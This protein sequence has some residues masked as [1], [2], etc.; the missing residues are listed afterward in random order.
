MDP[1]AADLF[2]DR[3]DSPLS[4]TEN[5]D[6]QHYCSTRRSTQKKPSAMGSPAKLA[7]KSGRAPPPQSIP[8]SKPDLPLPDL[9]IYHLPSLA[10]LASQ[11]LPKGKG[12]GL[13]AMKSFT[14]RG[15]S[16]AA[17]L[18]FRASGEEPPPPLSLRKESSSRDAPGRQVSGLALKIIKKLQQ[19]GRSGKTEARPHASHEGSN[20][21]GRAELFAR[22]P[23]DL[24][25]EAVWLLERPDIAGEA[26]EQLKN[27]MNELESL[28][29]EK[30]SGG[31]RKKDRVLHAH[32]SKTHSLLNS[33]VNT[34]INK[35][36]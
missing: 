10:R 12:K 25:K 29:N 26:K 3:F 24:K 35:T 28:K 9:G 6:Y 7:R 32:K 22:K 23:A 2:P 21:A 18:L 30:R 5:P 13:A 4:F 1:V 8:F 16:S 33:V 34:L 27:Y 15:N 14:Q 31:G 11:A 19:K 17:S 20:H 36:C